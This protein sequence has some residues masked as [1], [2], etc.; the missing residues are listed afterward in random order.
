[1]RLRNCASSQATMPPP[2]TITL[3]GMKSRSSTSSLVQNV[4]VRPSPGT[5]GTTDFRAGADEDM[6]GAKRPAVGKLRPCAESTKR[7]MG[8][9]Q[10]KFPDLQRLARGDSAKSAMILFSRV[11]RLHVGPGG[12]NLQ[13]EGLSLSGRG[14]ALPPCRAAF[15]TACSRAGCRVRPSSRAPSTMIVFNPSDQRAARH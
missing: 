9:D 3:F 14:A 15:S 4:R 1:M 10:F 11:D 8:A 2:S 7:R 12:R 5:G 6:S 13:A